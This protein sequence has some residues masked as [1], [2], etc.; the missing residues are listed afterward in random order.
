MKTN[1]QIWL[2]TVSFKGISQD[3][4]GKL[5]NEIHVTISRDTNSTLLN[6]ERMKDTRESLKGKKLKLPMNIEIWIF[7]R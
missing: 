6:E 2:D 7:Y 3:V 5:K 4:N 1:F